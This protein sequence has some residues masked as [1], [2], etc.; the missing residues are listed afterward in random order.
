MLR[1]KLSM[2]MASRKGFSVEPDILQNGQVSPAYVG[3]LD[4]PLTAV[5]I[6]FA[7]QVVA[8]LQPTIRSLFAS[9]LRDRVV[10]IEAA[11]RIVERLMSETSTRTLINTTHLE[12]MG[13]DTGH[14]SLVVS[15]LMIAFGRNLGL[16]EETVR[17]LGLGGLLHDV[18][19]MVLPVRLLQKPSEFSVAELIVIRTHPE[20]GHQMIVQIEGAPKAVLDICLHH[21][22]RYDGTGY[23]HELAGKDIPHVALI[24]AICDVYAA[25]TAARPYKRAWSRSEAIGAMLGSR[26][27]FDPELLASFVNLLTADCASE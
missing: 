4:M 1:H 10:C 14:H 11:R 25:L 19:K 6:K 8:E 27:H 21:H 15:A 13:E 5:Q 22:E 2:L 20:L 9:I 16:S 17:L 26:G 7:Q 23:P 24:A 18:G 3:V 12:D